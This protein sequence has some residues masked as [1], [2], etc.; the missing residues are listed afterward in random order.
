LYKKYPSVEGRV[1]QDYTVSTITLSATADT[2]RLS[3]DSK[4]RDSVGTSYMMISLQ[5]SQ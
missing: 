2:Y 5:I 4:C 1:Q 3:V